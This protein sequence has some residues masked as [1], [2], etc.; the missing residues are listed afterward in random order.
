MGIGTSTKNA[1]DSAIALMGSTATITPYTQTTSDSGYGGQVE[2]DGN[3][4]TE[5]AV[6]FSEF[7]NI[8]KQKFGDLEIGGFMLA[9]KST[10]TFDIS[11]TIKYKITYNEEIYDI[12]K[13]QRFFMDNTLLAWIITLDKRIDD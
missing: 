10:V 7:K 2:T 12:S 6:P 5:E 13:V 8:T 4:V 3:P 11:G 1:I 9:L